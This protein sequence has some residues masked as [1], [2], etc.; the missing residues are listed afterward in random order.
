[1]DTKTVVNQAVGVSVVPRRATRYLMHLPV[2]FQWGYQ[3]RVNGGTG[4]TRD[5]ST[6]GVFVHSSM[7]PP[8]G[9]PIALEVHLPPM[10]PSGPGLRLQAEGYVVRV[11]GIEEHAGFAVAAH[12]GLHD[13]LNTGDQ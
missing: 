13:A 7:A 9:T 3:G 5:I 8:V 4:F 10:A 1:M 11:E 2:I 12:F 6:G